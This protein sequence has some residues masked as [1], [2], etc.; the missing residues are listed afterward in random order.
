VGLQENDFTQLTLQMYAFTCLNQSF[1]SGSI[2]INKDHRRFLTGSWRWIRTFNMQRTLQSWWVEHGWKPWYDGGPS[3]NCFINRAS[4]SFQ[5]LL[6]GGGTYL[7]WGSSQRWPANSLNI[8]DMRTTKGRP[9]R[10]LKFQLAQRSP[11]V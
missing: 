3:L 4:N 2:A 9:Q 7:K 11:P 1:N 10:N 8:D 5:W 6:N